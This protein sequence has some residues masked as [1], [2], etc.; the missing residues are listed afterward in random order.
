M[1]TLSN[2][3]SSSNRLTSS[4]PAFEGYFQV[5]KNEYYILIR[6][7]EAHNVRTFEHIRNSNNSLMVYQN[8]PH[9]FRCLYLAARFQS[10]GFV[11]L[12]FLSLGKISLKISDKSFPFTCSTIWKSVCAMFFLYENKSLFEIKWL[13]MMKIANML[14]D[15]AAV[16][17]ES[18][19]LYPLFNH[20]VCR[21]HCHPYKRN[22]CLKRATNDGESNFQTR[23][24]L[25]WA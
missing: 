20:F 8:L 21:V 5:K 15:D 17:L 4:Q 16:L 22:A 6:W 25:F 19:N 9:N 3:T 10:R 14:L 23:L 7:K 11:V 12:F 18:I 2:L 1:G 13:N 24:S